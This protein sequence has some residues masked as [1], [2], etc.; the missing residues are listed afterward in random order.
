MDAAVRRRP[1]PRT[2]ATRARLLDAAVGE[3][4]SRGGQLELGSVARAAGVVPSV[5]SHHF[6]SRSGLVCAVVDGFFDALQAQVLD[7]D[8]R[9]LGSWHE[10][11]LER[12]RRG[13]RFHFTEPLA[14]V[15]YASLARDAE[16]AR[17]EATRI[18]LVVEASARNIAAAQ[19]DGEL[20]RS[21][22]PQLAA[23][24][25]FGAARQLTVTALTARRR[26]TQRSV[27][28]Q[29]WRVT[30]AAVTPSEEEQP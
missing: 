20:A 19:R 24:A 28:D 25:I 23:A 9:G 11:E 14:P 8:L 27:V 21:I 10:R 22:D 29:L 17:V 6:G 15:V 1:D 18:G 4:L 12:V 3:L 30:V 5:A 16:V 13:V 7:A 26:P 2:A